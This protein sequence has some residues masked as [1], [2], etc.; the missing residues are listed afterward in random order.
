MSLYNVRAHIGLPRSNTF[1]ALNS[2]IETVNHGQAPAMKYHS[3]I[4][5][6]VINAK[7]PVSY[8]NAPREV[9]QAGPYRGIQLN[10]H[11]EKQFRGPRSVSS[12]QINQDSC[13]DVIRKQPQNVKYTQE[14]AVRRL[15]PPKPE[16]H[17]DL[18][19]KEFQQQIPPAPP[20]VIRQEGMPAC[21]PAPMVFREAPP[22]PP[23]RVPTQIIDVEADPVPP[24]ARKVIFEKMHDQPCKPPNILIEKWLPYEPRTRRV[25]FQRSCIQPPPNPKNVIIEW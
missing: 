18:I 9:V 13:P 19:I 23:P 3:Q 11:E 7:Y 1:A 24:P 15:L 25:I 6:E 2:A 16:P 8:P 12:Y 4:E 22:A 17:G 14:V 20:V 5:D 21:D 10:K